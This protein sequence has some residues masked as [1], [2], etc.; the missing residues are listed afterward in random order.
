[1]LHKSIITMRTGI[2]VFCL[3][4]FLT[5]SESRS[6]SAPTTTSDIEA[7]ASKIMASTYYLDKGNSQFTI[8]GTSSLHDW[9]MVSNSFDGSLGSIGEN[10]AS[11]QFEK[12]EVTV[13]VES[14]L[15]GKKV[16]DKKCY[17]ALKFEEHPKIRY[18]FR[19][20]ENLK[21]TGAENYTA[22]FIGALTV[23]GQ[24]KTVSIPVS[25][26]QKGNQIR[27]EGAKPLKMSDFDVTPPKALLGTLKT[28]NEIT[29]V[30]NLNYLRS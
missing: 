30:F 17:E 18:R 13:P 16:M 27:I 3:F 20:M 19:K 24:T 1:M 10:E 23:A 4:M 2:A 25:I 8:Q 12:I 26:Q 7:S 22:T 9:E 14:L 6:Q 29:I 21:P 28:G 11:L 5:S 15:S